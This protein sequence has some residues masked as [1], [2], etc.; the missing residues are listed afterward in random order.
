[1]SIEEMEKSKYFLGEL[2]KSKE[3]WAWEYWNE[4]NQIFNAI[5]SCIDE[6]KDL[7]ESVARIEKTI[8]EELWKDE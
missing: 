8:R 3:A 7:R 5:G 4:F 6:L 2:I 1:M